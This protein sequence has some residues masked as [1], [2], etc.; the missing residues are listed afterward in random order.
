MW[1]GCVILGAAATSLAPGCVSSQKS[2]DPDA[3][4]SALSPGG[5]K[6]NLEKGKTK[7]QDVLIA[8]GTPDLVT[9]KDGQEI[10]TYDKTTYEYEK[11]SDYATLILI[12][13]GGDR[14]RS[15]SRSTLLIVYFD[16]HETV[17]DYRLSAVKY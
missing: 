11:R 12:G 6:L 3:T 14:V 1:R 15:T 5:V 10:W 7:Q 8:F 4:K 9:H 13:Q 16:D 2:E 17:I